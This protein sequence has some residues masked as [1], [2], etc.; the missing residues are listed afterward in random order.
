MTAAADS[1]GK[2]TAKEVGTKVQESF[3]AGV[4]RLRVFFREQYFTHGTWRTIP[5]IVVGV[6]VFF[7]LYVVSALVVMLLLAPLSVFIDGLESSGVWIG[8]LFAAG[9]VATSLYKARGDVKDRTE[10]YELCQRANPN[11][12]GAAYRYLD[13]DDGETRNN[14]VLTIALA[15]ENAPGKVI[16]EVPVSK[17]QLVS[18]LVNLLEDEHPD[19]RANAASALV[20][21]SR[22]YTGVVEPHTEEIMQ[23]MSYT[24]AMKGDLAI[25]LGNIGMDYPKKADELAQTIDPAVRDE[26]PEVRHNAAV[27]LGQL[28]SEHAVERLQH[29]AEDNHPEVREMANEALQNLVGGSQADDQRPPEPNAPGSEQNGQGDGGAELEFISNSPDVDFDDIAGMESLKSRLQRTVIDPFDTDSEAYSKFGVGSESGILLHGP[30]GTG[31]THIATC[32]AGELGANYAGIDVGD[33]ESKWLGEGVENI[34][35]LFEEAHSSQPALIFIDEIDA[36]G[37]DRGSDSNMHEDKKKMVNQLLQ[38]LSDIEPED[39]LLVIAATNRPDDVDE[40]MLRSGRFDSKIEVPKPDKEARWEIFRHQLTGPSESIGED[41]FVRETSGFSASD[42][43]EVGRRAARKAAVRQK[44]TERETKITEEDVFESVAQVADEKSEVGKFIRNPPEIDFDDVVGMETLKEELHEKVIDPLENPEHYEEF[45]L[46]V[47]N[48]FL[49]YGPPGTGKTYVSKALAGELDVNYIEAKAGDLASKY[50]G[51]GAE[52]VQ[53]MFA[54]AKENQ[55]TLVFIDEI[56]AL[57]TDRQSARQSKSERQMV[58]QFLE[59]LSDINDEDADVIVI[60]ATNL[61]EEVDDAMLRSGR[62]GEKIEVPPPDAETRAALFEAHLSAPSERI[63]SQW[64]A[65]QTSGFVA[66]DMARLADETARA[67]MKRYR[68]N[69]GSEKVT[70]LDVETALENVSST[71]RA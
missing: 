10:S 41:R 7:A 64:I 56:D 70:R 42:I 68:N 47:E 11:N 69:A 26:D 16:K 57:A 49:L 32:L 34:K 71:I 30:P 38:E 8:M 43:V 45:G 67:A 52:N 50:I 29:L 13:S 19:A 5:N 23:A 35:Q 61:V 18:D 62:L 54:E 15:S 37:A 40:A 2:S 55:P 3:S 28:Q 1:T 51:E 24:G 27:A 46:G 60:A 12:A 63:D 9:F 39:D 4:N 33:I 48:G 66:S 17:E 59:E 25:A 31:K 22:D 44:E 36:L 58:N 14:G 65:E 20:W 21:Y 6:L 53:E